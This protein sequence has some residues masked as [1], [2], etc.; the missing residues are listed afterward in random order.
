MPGSSSPVNHEIS[1]TECWVQAQGVGTLW[2]DWGL[3]MLFYSPGTYMSQ[4][5]ILSD[6]Q[7]GR[8]DLC[9]S[10]NH[11]QGR[12]CAPIS[13]PGVCVWVWACVF[14]WCVPKCVCDICVVCMR[15]EH[16]GGSCVSCVCVCVCV[17][18][19]VWCV[20]V[21]A[22]V[23]VHP[24]SRGARGRLWGLRS[25]ARAERAGPGRN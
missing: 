5:S 4:S 15:G 2:E 20:N 24:P 21:C 14:L 12:L 25:T 8:Q 17:S 9:E 18:M 16:E 3:L 13:Q 23:C 19:H 6:P 10:A 1:S 7:R 22:S 11:H